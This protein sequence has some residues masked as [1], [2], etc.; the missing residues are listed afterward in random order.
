MYHDFDYEK[1]LVSSFRA[2]WQLDDVLRE[3]QNRDFSRNFL[4]ESLTRTAAIESLNPFEQ[5]I[6]DQISAHRIFV[7][8]RGGRGIH[9]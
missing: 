3:N 5:R 7:D 1:T 8:L 9:S 6:L 4:P 2:Q